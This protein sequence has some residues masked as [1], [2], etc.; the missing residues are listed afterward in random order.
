MPDGG[1][2]AG[3]SSCSVAGYRASCGTM[4]LLIA[5]P[6]R[7]CIPSAHNQVVS[8]IPYKS[9][10]VLFF[11][12]MATAT[13]VDVAAVAIALPR[14]PKGGGRPRSPEGF[15]VEGL[16]VLV[17][18]RRSLMGGLAGGHPPKLSPEAAQ[19]HR[20]RPPSQGGGSLGGHSQHSRPAVACHLTSRLP[21]P[22]SS[23]AGLRSRGGGTAGR[24]A[25]GPARARPLGARG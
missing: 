19:C 18:R 14:Q 23:C 8:D 11:S 21:E 7:S 24:G 1:A 9:R 2:A 20:T 16:L 13:A 15:V 10:V 5:T 25:S 17:L 4:R 6:S 22:H 12:V 3:P